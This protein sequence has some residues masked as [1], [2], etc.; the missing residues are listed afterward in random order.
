MEVDCYLIGIGG[1][2]AKCVESF[3]HLAAANLLPSSVRIGLVDQDESNGNL[4]RCKDTLGLYTKLYQDLRSGHNSLKGSPFLKTDLTYPYDKQG[5]PGEI[6]VWCP[7]SSVRNLDAL[8]R[9]EAM[10][11]EVKYLYQCLFSPN[12]RIADLKV[13]FRG[14]PYIGA[15]AFLASTMAGTPFD[16]MIMQKV[17]D[18]IQKGNQARIYLLGSIFGGT[19]AAGMPVIAR[20]LHKA[21]S[22]LGRKES[23]KIGGCMMLPYFQFGSKREEDMLAASDGAFIEQTQGALKYYHRLLLS[24]HYEESPLFDSLSFLGWNP[25]INL[26]YFAEGNQA[27]VNPSLLPE[28]YAALAATRF[29]ANPLPGNL[30]AKRPEEKISWYDLPALDYGNPSGLT[31]REGVGSLVRFC[32]AYL[33]SYF[34]FMKPENAS[35][36]EN[37]PWWRRLLAKKQVSPTDATTSDT[38]Q[39]LEKYSKMVLQ[40]AASLSY[41]PLPESQ[42]RADLFQVKAF[43]QR[44]RALQ[45]GQVQLMDYRG[46]QREEFSDLVKMGKGLSLEDVYEKMCTRQQGKSMAS[47]MELDGLGWFVGHLYHHCRIYDDQKNRFN[48]AA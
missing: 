43:A 32:F 3:I 33:A 9:S 45:P 34:P 40:W 4:A 28:L 46:F 35:N 30:I 6:S 39:S 38:L 21:M 18:S 17:K 23:L 41:L 36:Y 37:Q 1:T 7:V 42:Q 15:A 12:D 13:G 10:S 48:Q 19:G 16:K 29:F 22:G 47:K 8:F 26:G 20:R 2:G 11:P 44:P 5:D 24:E 25:L 14:R 31:V 27:Q